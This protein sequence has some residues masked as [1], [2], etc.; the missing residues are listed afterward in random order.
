M[1]ALVT[2]V[3]GQI[4]SYLAELLL[5]K[6]Y[7]IFGLKRR[8]SQNSLQNIEGILNQIELI[9]G[10]LTDLSSLE[11][12]VRIAE[13]DEVYN[14]AAQSFV[15]ESFKTPIATANI[16]GLGVLNMLEA[17]RH[18]APDAKFV[19]MS[20]SEMFGSN[21]P[22]QNESTPF[23][24]RSPYGVAKCFG[25]WSA[26][27]ARE[28]YGLK[29]SNAIGFNNESPRRGA[30]FV[31]RKITL[32]IRDIRGGGINKIKLGNL[33]AKRD[34]SFTGDIVKGLYLIANHEPDDFVLCSGE[35]HSVRDFCEI[36]F[37]CVGLDYKDYIEIDP[38]LFRPAEVNHLY[39][40]YSKAK[41]ELGWEPKV[42]F[43][44]LVEMMVNADAD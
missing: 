37:N 29:V 36:A 42:K 17:V 5:E 1:N 30:H 34:W 20:T 33:D 27:N 43:K 19:Q 32:G 23:H 9:E 38:L 8:T 21:P 25:F 15:A 31:T 2:G 28:S 44:E 35:A 18:E 22:P 4:G 24:P 12:A 6:G 10:D 7:K 26:V 41:K 13:P 40:D 14:L 3:N 16:T 39:G 11:R